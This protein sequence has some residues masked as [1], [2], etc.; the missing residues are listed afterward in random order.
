MDIKIKGLSYEILVKA[1]EQARV[2]RLEILNEL[3]NTIEQP[4]DSVKPHAPKMVKV[5]IDGD[6]IGA[7]LDLVEKLFKKCKKKLDATIVIEEEDEK[8]IIEILGT[9]QEMIDTVIQKIDD[10]TFKP[11]YGK[12][13]D[14]KVVKILEFGAVVEF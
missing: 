9:D 4:N 11:E 12:E 2:G 10:I 3:T 6:Y 7:V 1:L 5:V 13:Y 14:V 8:G